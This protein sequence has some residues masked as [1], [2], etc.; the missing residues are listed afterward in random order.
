M[1]A[2]S[3]TPTSRRSSGTS[4]GSRG[5]PIRKDRTFFFGGAEWLV[6]SLGLT[7][8]TT[9]PSVAARAGPIDSVVQPYLDLFPLPN[10]PELGG[11]LAR[12]TFPF[13]PTT[14]ETR[15]GEDRSQLLDASSLFVRYTID[16]AARRLPTSLPQ[17]SSDRKSR[18]QWLTIEEKRTVSAALLNTARFSYS[19]VKL[20]ARG[21]RGRRL[22][23]GLRSRAD[24]I[25]NIVIGSR[26]FG[27]DR[28]SP[29]H[30]DIEYFTFSDDVAYSR[31][32]HFL[33]AGV[34]IERAHTD[35][36]TVPACGDDTNFRTCRGFSRGLVAL[37]RSAPWHEIERSRRNTTFGFYVQDDLTAHARLTLNLG[38]R[39]KF[40]RC[41][42]T[43]TG[44]IRP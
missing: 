6:E 7:R 3:S 17:F 13:D 37:H 38:L 11:G 41:R 16:D 21:H 5:G 36:G 32:R 27:P 33:K 31:G 25:G 9:V 22:R 15:A 29:Q 8:V 43:R 1:R 24:D 12:F 4:S 2:T 30:Q 35:T 40:Y 44:A 14:G 23:A 26:E 34:L 19:R 20:G 10:G 42:T 28:T 39:Y 18:N